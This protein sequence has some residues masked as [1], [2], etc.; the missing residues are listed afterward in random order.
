MSEVGDADA[1][2]QERLDKEISAYNAAL[3]GTMRSAC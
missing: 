2:L 1:G 3:T